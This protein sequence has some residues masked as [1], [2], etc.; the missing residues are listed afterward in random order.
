MKKTLH[1]DEAEPREA[2]E[3]CGASADTET[4]RLGLEA[5]IRHAVYQRL[6]KPRARKK[7]PQM[8]RGAGENCPFCVG[9]IIS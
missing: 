6:R 7:S 2:K 5:S 3:A 4:V 9:S 1:T 8:F